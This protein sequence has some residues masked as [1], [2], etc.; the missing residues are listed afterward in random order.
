M[1]HAKLFGLLLALSGGLVPLPGQAAST[2]DE[3]LTQVRRA[4][5]ELAGQNAD[6]ERRFLAERDAQRTRLTAAQAELDVERARGEELQQAFEVNREALEEFE[7][8]LRERSG[9]LFDV[10]G[11]ARQSAAQARAILRESLVT[12]QIPGREKPLEELAASKSVPS[13][14]DLETLWYTLQQE[15]T[16]SGKVVTYPA[17]VVSAD[18]GESVRRVTRVGLF[19]AVADGHFLRY[20]PNTG[21]FEELPRQPS[22]HY[23]EVASALEGATSGMVPMVL[24]PTRG[25]VLGLLVRVP[26]LLERVQQGRLVGYVIIGVAVLGILIALECWARLGLVARRIR[27]QLDT[28]VPNNANPLGRVMEVYR[29]NQGVSSETLELLIDEA[30]L[31]ETPRLQRGLHALKILAMIAPLLGLLGTVVGLI[32]TFQSITLFG[33]GDPGLMAGGISQALVTTVLGLIAAIPLILTH[34]ALLSKSRRLVEV[35]D[36]Q[37]IGIIARHAEGRESHAAAA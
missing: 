12:T 16:E 8:K 24:D 28:R 11:T 5:T 23:R 36:Q 34:S 35:L 1:T 10:F 31:K 15:M 32:Q 30:I 9:E 7:A 3:L 21:K 19:T 22:A 37:S 4:R 25:A 20:L 29:Q 18:G 14:G 17:P 13:I 33:T 26:D 2:L 6:R 27:R